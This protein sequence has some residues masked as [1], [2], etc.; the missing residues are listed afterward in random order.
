MSGSLTE[1]TCNQNTFSNTTNLDEGITI[2]IIVLNSG[3]LLFFLVKMCKLCSYA[4]S[5]S[6]YHIHETYKLYALSIMNIMAAILVRKTQIDLYH[7]KHPDNNNP[8]P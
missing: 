3:L 4:F 8:P 2:T 7:F 5:Y 1:Y 6:N